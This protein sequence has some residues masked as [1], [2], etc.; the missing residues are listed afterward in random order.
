MAKKADTDVGDVHAPVED[1]DVPLMLKVL[2][3][4]MFFAVFGFG[5]YIALS[6]IPSMLGR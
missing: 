2:V 5:L 6:L 1:V 4:V 3:L